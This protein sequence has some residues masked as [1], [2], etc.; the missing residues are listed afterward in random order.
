MYANEETLFQDNTHSDSVAA[1]D[2]FHYTIS[3]GNNQFLISFIAADFT[4]TNSD[5]IFPCAGDELTTFSTSVTQSTMNHK[6]SEIILAATSAP[7]E[8]E[9]VLIR[10]NPNFSSISLSRLDMSS[11]L[12]PNLI[13]FCSC[14]K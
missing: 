6:N 12:Y 10:V 7:L 13:A 14:S 9:I 1:G 8:F 5:T 4:S 2:D 11:Y 3:V